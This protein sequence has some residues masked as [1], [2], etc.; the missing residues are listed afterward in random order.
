M[1]QVPELRRGQHL[2][3]AERTRLGR[4]LVKRYQAGLSVRQIC[5]ETGYSIG[6]VRRLLEAGGVEYRPRGGAHPRSP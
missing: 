1:S 6:R 4:Q 2:P 3:D 5:A